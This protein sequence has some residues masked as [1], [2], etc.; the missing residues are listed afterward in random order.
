V[1][2]APAG[3]VRSAAERLHEDLAATARLPVERR[4]SRLLGEAEAV[5]GDMR[6]C[7]DAVIVE[8]AAIVSD[9]LAE[10]EATGD[11]RADAHLARARALAADLSRREPG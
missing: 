8:R 7:D 11:G 5:A 10:V 9:L 6:S 4:A 3:D 2:D 1:T